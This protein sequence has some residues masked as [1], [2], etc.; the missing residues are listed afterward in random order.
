VIGIEQAQVD[1]KARVLYYTAEGA[2]GLMRRELD[3]GAERLVTPAITP[4]LGGGWRVVDGRIWYFAELG[5]RNAALR[6]LDPATGAD[7]LVT[8]LDLLIGDVSFSVMPGGGAIL[9]AP[10]DIEDTD[11]GALRLVRAGTR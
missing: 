5:I 8:R 11:I 9:F 1:R 2:P 10:V 7:R 4:D 3:G 6:E